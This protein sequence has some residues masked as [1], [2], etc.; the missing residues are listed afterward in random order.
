MRHDPDAPVPAA[1]RPGC[2][3]A[4]RPE[5]VEQPG[6]QAPAARRRRRLPDPV[7]HP[8][9][10]SASVDSGGFNC[11]TRTP[12]APGC[13]DVGCKV[14][15]GA[16]VWVVRSQS[17]SSTREPARCSHSAVSHAAR[18]RPLGVVNS[19]TTTLT[20]AGA[21]SCGAME[22]A[23]QSLPTARTSPA[24]RRAVESVRKRACRRR[25]GASLQSQRARALI[26]RR[27]PSRRTDGRPS[28]HP[29]CR[30]LGAGLNTSRR[31][32]SP[33]APPNGSCYSP[34]R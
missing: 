5:L 31:S 10:T 8:A 9:M 18:P 34:L 19:P 20:W 24:N 1:E 3:A 2:E 16:T 22:L 21:G 6:M 23:S 11:T 26:A 13:G 28:K 14:P 12:P 25:R 15:Y 4:G 7:A 27:R 32:A 17:S 29:L 30:A 33:L